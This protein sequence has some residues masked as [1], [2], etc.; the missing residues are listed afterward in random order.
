[1]A[2][3]QDMETGDKRL[4]AGAREPLMQYGENGERKNSKG[5]LWMVYFSTFVAVCGSF[6]F[7]TCVG[8]SSPTQT[9]ITEDLNLSL[10][11]YSLF[12]S[13]LTFGAMIGAITSGTIAD[14]IGRKW[15]MRLSAVFCMAGWLAVYFAKGAVSLDLG[16]LSMGYGM[17]VFSYV[18]PVYISEISPKN[19]RGGLTTI[20]Q[21]MIG[22][23]GSF[24]FII[25]IVLSWRTLALI[26]LIPCFIVLLGLFFIPESPRWLAKKGDQKEFDA[27][28]QKLRGKDAD[29]SEEAAEI[30]DY[31][32]T[33]ESL[34]KAKIFDL[35][36]RRY[37]HSVMIGVGL[38]VIQ[39]FG[40]INGIYFY[41]KQTFV[42]AGFPAN[43]GTIS[44]AVIQVV[45][46]A[47]GA[48][49]VDHAG[50]RPLLLVSASGLVCG[51]I[52]A[53]T[54]FYLKAHDLAS[55]ATPILAIT[56][57]LLY[58]GAFSVG[59]GGT[60]WVI[61]SE[62]F[63]ITIKGVAG[64][65]ATTVNW[66]GAWTVS[67][68]FNYLMSWSTYGTFFLFAGI[69]ALGFLFIFKFI[70]ETKGRTLEE[71]QATINSSTFPFP[72]QS[73]IVFDMGIEE[74]ME[75]GE[76]RL[77]EEEL[78]EPLRPLSKDEEA[79]AEKT[80]NSNKESFWL[81]YLS[82]FVVVC[83]SFEFGSAMGYSS[84]TEIA[85]RKD[86]NL[87]TAE[88]SVFGSIL[89]LGAMFGAIMSGKVADLI[90]RKGAMRISAVFCIAGWFPIYFAKGPLSLDIGRICLGYGIGI[91][92]YVVPVYL[93]EIA[94]TNLRGGLTS[95]N[96]LM[97]CCAISFYYIVGIVLTWRTLALIGVIPCLI[98]LLGLFFIPESPR[99]LAKMGREKEFVDSLQQLR[100]KDF[101]ISREAAEIEDY[102]ET[103]RKLPKTRMLDLI[104]KRYLRSNIIA[105]GLMVFQQGGGISGITFY[106][107]KVFVSAG[108]SSN[109]GTIT[110][111]CLQVI[112]GTLCTILMDKAGRRSLL[113]VST[114]GMVLGCL[115]VG[116]SFYLKARELAS[117]I[118]PLL[119]IIGI[120]VYIGT[121]SVGMGITP[122]VIMSEIFPINVKGAAGSLAT[123][124]NWIGAWAVTYAFNFLMSW[125][126]YGT[127]IL[128]AAINALAVLF[129]AELVPETKGQ[130]LEQ[131]QAAINT[132]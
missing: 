103:L 127:F 113:L 120:L 57:I 17:G 109:I 72:V 104:Q 45:L 132:A 73:Y 22:S 95:V 83:G 56:G 65:L 64:S 29:T 61:M 130:T 44:Y 89:T 42:S 131:I 12:G 25:G 110:Y 126:S 76:N 35:F 97:V 123:L 111:A 92:S 18:V 91:F 101:N 31:I 85:M 2:I 46:T 40:G 53:G 4:L 24:F 80:C 112:I 27:A 63:P 7:G 102:V 77:L 94:P 49:L 6:E 54:S 8:Y 87:S 34:P 107:S 58:V 50:R 84:P 47:L 128:F 70:P 86:L 15:A 78:R 59:M 88:Y 33:L 37:M 3:D 108:F 117:H 23:G 129:V 10:A 32:E 116:T 55:T 28:L 11:E 20:N 13:I 43:V 82:T 52:L 96:Q 118:A 115:L 99:W 60:P 81:V 36:Q 125:S 51:C 119:A 68:T 1:M 41:V 114:S 62:V 71:I 66:F 100:G 26:G 74:D 122:W 48:T 16:R 90:G 9:A 105:V 38:M 79:A 30:Q 5:S 93:A 67:Y 69:N 21:L 124:V 75:I 19:L 106:V 14:F 39:Q 121:F 98:H